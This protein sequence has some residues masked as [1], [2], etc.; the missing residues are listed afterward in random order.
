M[1]L[2][3][4]GFYT[5]SDERARTSSKVSSLQRCEL[6]LTD[7]CNFK[8]PYCRGLDKKYRGDISLFYAMQIVTQWAEEG[9]KNIRFSGGEPTLWPRLPILIRHAKSLGIEHIALSTNGSARQEYY[10]TLL[11]A[12]INDFSI[13]LDACCSSTAD[14][15]SG[16]TAKYNQVLDNIAYLAKRSYVT[17]GVV[18]TEKNMSELPEIIKVGLSI[19]V[20]DIRIIPAAQCGDTFP[21]TL[22]Q[23]VLKDL[24]IL[25]YR[26][27]NICSG[28][29]V[30]G[31]SRQDNRRCPLVLDDMAIAQNYHFPCIIYMREKGNPVGTVDNKTMSQIRYERLVWSENHD[32]Y[33]DIICRGNCLDVCRDYNNRWLHFNLNKVSLPWMNPGNFDWLS[34]RGG[35]VKDFGCSARWIDMTENKKKLKT[36]AVGWCLSEEVICRPKENQVAVMF[37]KG[38]DKFW[39]H[40]WKNEFYEVFK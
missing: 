11:D 3:E 36:F 24:P 9:L 34:W 19:G 4:I 33:L 16:N 7:T 32:C 29:S 28:V 25:N 1:N 20:S 17:L 27:N 38:E 37:Q 22:S 13:S 5:L 40:M 18:L 15:M 39:F 21:I 8:C 14:A 10:Q 12:G 6:I 23:R 2:E 31:L 35:S 30:R 26:L